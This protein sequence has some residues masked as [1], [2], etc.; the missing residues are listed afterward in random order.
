MRGSFGNNPTQEITFGGFPMTLI[1]NTVEVGDWA[2]EFK[3]I[4][5]RFVGV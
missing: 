3:A 4:K 1:G 2:S 5:K